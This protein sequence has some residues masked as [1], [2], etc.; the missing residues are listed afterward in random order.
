MKHSLSLVLALVCLAVASVSM[1]YPSL[2]G[3]TGTGVLPDAGVVGDGLL[4]IAADA[5]NAQQVS[6]LSLPIRLEYGVSKKMELGGVITTG[7]TSAWNLNG[8]ISYPTSRRGSADCAIGARF[9]YID[10]NQFDRDA[11]QIYGVASKDF[12]SANTNLRGSVGLSWT[13]IHFMPHHNA[14]AFRPFTGLNFSL[15]HGAN[16]MIDYQFRSNALEDNTLYSIVA[17]IPLSTLLTGEIGFTNMN[18]DGVT[19]NSS[20]GIF[21]GVN[22]AFSSEMH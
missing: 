8:K 18:L 16:V 12:H 17:R 10:T 19:G 15:P 2:S 4:H 6:G 13:D 3:P 5:Y 11:Y 7:N 14:S 20:T 21:A 1:A 9:S 22:Y